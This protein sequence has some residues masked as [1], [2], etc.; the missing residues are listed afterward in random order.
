MRIVI[1][2]D[3]FKGNL[4][5]AEVAEA[6]AR[7]VRLAAPSAEIDLCPMADGGE[8]TV[9][10]LVAATGG[11]LVTRTVTGPLPEMKVAATFGILGARAGEPRTAVIE[12]AAASGLALLRPDQ[13]DPLATTTFG[14]GELVRAAAEMGV[15][16]ILLGI[17]GSATIDGGIGC[18]QAA[19]LPVL[20]RDGEPTSP[21][22]PLC[23][24]D[25]PKVVLVKHGRGSPVDGVT[26][27]V[28]CDVT[29]PLFG[30][31]G[32]AAVFGPQKGASP[33]M[34]GELDREL[35]RLA[36]RL[37]KLD[38]AQTPGS[39]AAGG[40]GFGM[41]AFFGASLRSGVEI[42]ADAVGL[43]RRLAG[44]NLCL[45]GEGRLDDQSA[46]G[47]TVAGVAHACR[48]AGVPCIALAGTIGPGA[49]AVLA[50]GVTAYFAI[51]DRPMQIAESMSRSRDLLTATA[52]NVVRLSA[53]PESLSSQN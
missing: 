19:G 53:G 18:A 35:R 48:A 7:G 40:L 21:T 41:M 45:T 22:E 51:A 34:V 15:R 28:A 5:A 37:G 9:A 33:A 17:G 42:V 25:L 14:T 16:N 3:K 23:G 29:N 43:R 39:G 38:I 30:P 11:T 52:A 8:G 2:P 27:T 10:A 26:V 13:F 46:A 44:A 20:L 1:A 6:I 36:E 47:K 24:R 4:T 32:A 50:E 31:S 49:D 12:M